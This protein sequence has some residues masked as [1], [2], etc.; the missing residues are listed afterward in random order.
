MGA[1]ML[2]DGIHL[3]L[4]QVLGLPD[5]VPDAAVLIDAAVHVF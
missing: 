3:L 5:D 4:R 2:D 1:L